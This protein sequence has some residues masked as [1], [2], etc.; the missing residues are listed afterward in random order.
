MMQEVSGRAARTLDALGPVAYAHRGK[1]WIHDD[2]VSIPLGYRLWLDVI[3]EDDGTF[4]LH[5]Y[6]APRPFVFVDGGT[7][8][9]VDLIDLQE[10]V[11]WA[12]FEPIEFG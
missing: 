8:E 2:I 9:G 5:R 6:M 4:T 3:L 12:G 11:E 1:P 10:A 7:M